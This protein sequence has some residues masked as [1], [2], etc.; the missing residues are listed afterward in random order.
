MP[1]QHGKPVAAPSAVRARGGNFRQL[2]GA[3]NVTPGEHPDPSLLV[4]EFR[5]AAE[6]AKQ[7]GFDGIELHSANGCEFSFSR[8]FNFLT[9][10]DLILRECADLVCI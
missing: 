9:L 2:G 4:E 3:E 5:R 1:L 6:Y 7:A 10:S 8:D